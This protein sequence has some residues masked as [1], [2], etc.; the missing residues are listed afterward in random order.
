MPRKNKHNKLKRKSDL[1]HE[2]YMGIRQ[3]LFYNEIMPGQKIKYQDLANRLGV[4]ITPVIHALKWLEFK[5]IVQHERNKGYYINEINLQEVGE[6]YDTRLALEVSVLPKAL[7]NLDE[8]GIE[9]MHSSLEAWMNAVKKNDSYG[10]LITDMKF[11][12]TLTSLSDCRIQLKMLQEL[13]DFLLL[14]Y[15]RNLVFLS[16]MES[17]EREHSQI[18]AELKNRNLPKLQKALSDHIQNVRDYILDGLKRIMVGKKELFADPYS[19]H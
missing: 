10:R 1:D 19:F 18:L 17:T 12:L 15:S 16:L 5:G 4:S 14:K 13:F 6:I 2:A 3:M 8:N 11:H 7:K 9:R